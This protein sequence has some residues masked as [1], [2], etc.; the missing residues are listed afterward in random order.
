MTVTAVTYNTQYGVGLDGAYSIERI[1]DAVQEAD[2]ICLQEVTRG[3]IRNEGVDMVAGLHNALPD[4]FIAFQ[5]AADVDMGSSVIEGQATDR[6]LQ[7]GNAVISRWPIGSIR[8]HLLPRTWRKNRL[9]LQ[10][11]ALEAGIE[12]PL[13]PMRFYSVHLDHIDAR[14]RIAQAR[15]LRAIALDF[16]KTGGA[17][18]GASEFGLPDG[19]D[20]GDFL[21][22]GDFNCEPGTDPYLTLTEDGALVD[23]S[24]TDPGWTWRSSSAEQPERRAR[25][26]YM[27]ANPDL[28]SR[29]SSIHIDRSQDGSD[30]MPIWV[31]IGE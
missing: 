3:F 16:D 21:L 25:L 24:A 20:N 5:A 31:T 1:V 4:R 14:E 8:T 19:S 15:A 28:A 2:I 18:T 29:I 11:G 23:I 13:G 9:N 12:T 27:F 10:R 6:R 26:D 7:F 17:I 22:M 30:H